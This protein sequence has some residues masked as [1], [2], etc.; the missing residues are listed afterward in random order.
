[1][2][3]IWQDELAGHYHPRGKDIPNECKKAAVSQLET[4]AFL[5]G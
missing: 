2:P 5:S 4:A 1:M 3:P